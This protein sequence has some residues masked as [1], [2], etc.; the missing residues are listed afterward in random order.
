MKFEIKK[1]CT[2]CALFLILAFCLTLSS[3][4]HTSAVK[5]SPKITYQSYIDFF[6]KVY[7]TMEDNYY[8]PVSRDVY[9]GFIQKF[10]TK[11]YGELKDQ[12]KSIDFIRWRSSASLMDNLKSPEDIF[13]AFYPPEPAKEYEQTALGKRVDLGV[14]G[15]LTPEGYLIA[16]V[17]PRSD[18]Y[19]QGL[20]DNDILLRIDQSN[21]KDLDEQ[22]IN[23]LLNPLENAAVSIHFWDAEEGGEKNIQVVSKEYFKQTVFMMPINIPSIYGLEIRRF[24]RMTAEDLFRFLKFFKENGVVRGL[25]LDLRN[26]PGGP[27]L[28]ARE[29]ASFF[30]PGG[31]DFAYFQKKG[32]PKSMLD[33]PNL[34]EEFRVK[35]P[36]V[37]LVNKESGSASELFSGVLQRRGRAILMGTNSAGQVML[38]SMFPMNDQS[39]MLLV[40]ARGHHPDG[41]VFSF[42]GLTPDRFVSDGEQDKILEYAT[43][44][45]VYVHMSQ[46]R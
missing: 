35:C 42:D 38:K 46:T 16:L 31:E 21:I 36:M 7:K 1:Y 24:N 33:V 18:A 20:R 17:E 34:P 10:T 14:E 3:C 19:Q 27:P 22:E 30:L 11:I 8:Q 28:A 41:G 45:L 43:K 13:S 23:E 32:Q 37:I 2:P 40:T 6:E 4:A 25:I 5:S 9:E 12:G 39:M 26:N 29:I 15:K 44:Y